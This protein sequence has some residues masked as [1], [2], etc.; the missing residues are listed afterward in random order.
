M[1]HSRSLAYTKLN[2]IRRF[3]AGEPAYF[4]ILLAA[5]LTERRPDSSGP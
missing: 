3:F 1:A 5:G 2:L 4:L